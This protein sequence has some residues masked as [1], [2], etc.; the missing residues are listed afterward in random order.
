M[1]W[2]IGSRGRMRRKWL[3]EHGR[4]LNQ[5][6]K[7]S[8]QHK[9][10]AVDLP[11]KTGTCPRFNMLTNQ[12]VLGVHT[13]TDRVCK[14][15]VIERRVGY[16]ITK[17]DTTQLICTTTQWFWV[18]NGAGWL[19]ESLVITREKTSKLISY[20]FLSASLERE[21]DRELITLTLSNQA[22][23]PPGLSGEVNQYPWG[24][25]LLNLLGEA[26]S[27][28]FCL[29]MSLTQQVHCVGIWTRRTILSSNAKREEAR[30]WSHWS[31]QKAFAWRV[32]GRLESW[33]SL[34]CEHVCSNVIA[35]DGWEEE[36]L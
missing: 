23:S 12:S 17:E 24:G 16:Y 8:I 34:M 3:G 26:W 2:W 15:I 10:W 13:N 27:L 29:N 18:P 28:F 14:S 36:C 6:R 5:V 32:L 4:N 22:N 35:P 9:A 11:T 21:G 20:M 30:K 25:S 1:E 19:K 33:G 7:C 31:L